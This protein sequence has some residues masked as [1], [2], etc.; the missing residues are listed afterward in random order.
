MS[1]D[2]SVYCYKKYKQRLQK[3]KKAHERYQ[4]LFKEGKKGDK[5][6]VNDIT[7]STKMKSKS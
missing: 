4:D 7:I 3:K 1:K 5:I 2:S 6:I